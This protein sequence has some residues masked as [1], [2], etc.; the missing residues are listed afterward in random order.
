MK[1]ILLELELTNFCNARCVMCPVID[2]KRKKGFM[3]RETFEMNINKGI[4]YGIERIRF[5]G[6]GEPLLHKHFCE[7]LSHV[8]KHNLIA[9]LIT[10][11]ALLNKDIVQC[12]IQHHIDSLSISFP[13]L[14]K[15]NYERIMKGLVFEKVFENVLFAVRELK[16][17]R[18]VHIQI[19]STM[20]GINH[21][22]KE[23]IKHFWT[24]EGVDTIELHTAHNRG[25]HLKDAGFLNLSSPSEDTTRS[26]HIKSL[27]PWPL[28]QFFI[29][30]DGSVYLC[31]CDME[32]EYTV[33]NIYMDNFS[34][35]ERTQESI[36]INQPDL[37]NR[38]SYQSA[39]VIS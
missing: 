25:G 29:G 11:G 32:G 33:G 7:F 35:M 19:T 21:E 6:L 10:N 16:K 34:D 15:E 13:S 38:C 22:E 5:C 4:E 14:I 1:K 31:C 12:L 9:E 26:G 23:Q 8:K 37:C 27:C 17:A 30:W 20:T 3:N 18:P 39:K 36:C 24:R 28:R 2:M